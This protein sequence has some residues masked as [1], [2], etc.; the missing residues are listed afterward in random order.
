MTILPVAAST[1]AMWLF[2]CSVTAI[3]SGL[4]EGDEFRLRILRRD[5]GDAGQVDRL[6]AVAIR[7]A[8]AERHDLQIAGRQLRDLAVVHLLVALV[9]DGDRSEGAVLA[10]GDRSPAGRR[11]R[12][13][14]SIALLARSMTVRLPDGLALLS[15]VLTRGEHLAAGDRDRGRLAVDLDDAAGL[16]RLGI[17]DVDEADRA[18]AG[19]RNRPACCRPRLAVMISDEVAFDLSASAGRLDATGKV[20]MRLNTMSAWAGRATPHDSAAA[21]RARLV[22]SGVISISPSASRYPLVL[23]MKISAA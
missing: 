7:H 9:L 20:A 11:G 4:V 12:R 1:M 14:F 19:C 6:D 17:G 5:L 21:N 18:V 3:S 23:P 16:R 2:S 10:D 22:F 13:S 8:G 15:E